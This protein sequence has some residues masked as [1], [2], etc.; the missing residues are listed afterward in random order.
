MSSLGTRPRPLAPIDEVKEDITAVVPDV[1][2]VVALVGDPVLDLH[3]RQPLDVV[4]LSVAEVLEF[5]RVAE[6][7]AAPVRVAAG[8][9]GAAAVAVLVVVPRV[10]VAAGA[11]AFCEVD[12]QGGVSWVVG[13]GGHCVRVVVNFRTGSV[14]VGQRAKAT[15]DLLCSKK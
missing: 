3:G 15:Y 1:S 14:L 2:V 6:V 8:R 5:V 7:L 11:V 12:G 13:V 10:A 4:E 9:D